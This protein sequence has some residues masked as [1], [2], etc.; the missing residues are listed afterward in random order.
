MCKTVW[1]LF[2]GICI[3]YRRRHGRSLLQG[4]VLSRR[5]LHKSLRKV[6]CR[7]QLHNISIEDLCFYWIFQGHSVGH[8]VQDLYRRSQDCCTRSDYKE[9]FC[10][11]SLSV[12]TR[13][14]CKVLYEKYLHGDLLQEV[15]LISLQTLQEPSARH[16][17]T[18]WTLHDSSAGHLF[19]NCVKPLCKRSLSWLYNV[20]LQQ[21]FL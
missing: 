11:R 3:D 17:F 1:C 6:L 15:P 21:I 10:R 2:E 4:K 20:P 8:S 14:P 18:T 12:S 7:S 19:Q 5:S 16:L 9:Y 13:S